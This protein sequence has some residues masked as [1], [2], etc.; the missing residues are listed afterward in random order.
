MLVI[1]GD[2]TGLLKAV[3]VSNNN[4][5]STYGDQSRKCSIKSMD[6][7]SS[8]TFT[9]ARDNGT[10]EIWKVENDKLILSHEHQSDL[11]NIVA[12]RRLP[13]KCNSSDA[14]VLCDN[15]GKLSVEK[16]DG[17]FERSVHSFDVAAPV[18]A[19]V[20]CLDGGVALG[21]RENDIHMYDTTTNQEVWKAKNVPHDKLSLRVPVW[22]TALA[23]L[24]PDSDTCSAA[25]MVSG[26]GHKH[27]R[28]YDTAA[29]RQPVVSID[30]GGDFRVTAIRP[31]SDGNGLFVADTAGGL[32]QWDLR[33]QRRIYTLKGSTGSIRDVQTNR[34]GSHLAA[35]GLDRYMRL[36]DARSNKPLSS[37]YMKNRLNCCLVG[38]G[39]L[40]GKAA[41]AQ[42]SGEEQE[43][44][45]GRSGVGR[46]VRNERDEDILE[47][48]SDSDDEEEDEED[49]G[50]EGSEDEGAEDGSESR[51]GDDDDESSDEEE[52]APVPSRPAGKR[53]WSQSKA[54]G[55]S[56]GKAAKASRR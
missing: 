20:T 30:I 41:A 39:E 29:S 25:H 32:Y 6:W 53:V 43:G 52:E 15:T 50:E 38:E 16:F 42:R 37:T 54:A 19:C 4:T 33:T 34:D 11:A 13:S 14:F 7:I 56:G 18:S 21:G 31:T 36:Y 8:D 24:R 12:V 49:S 27:V 55:A 10:V 48:Y 2:E 23:F 22:I 46:A 26:T 40:R 35:V 3:D 51:S 9:I 44:F 5:V 45:T 17:T 1:T 28:V 47:E